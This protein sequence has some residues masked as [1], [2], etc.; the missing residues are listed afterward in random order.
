[1]CLRFELPLFISS[2]VAKCCKVLHTGSN[3]ILVLS[4]SVLCT[5]FHVLLQNMDQ[6]PRA[7]VI[8]SIL[9]STIQLIVN[10]FRYSLES[11]KVS[12]MASA[13]E[14]LDSR[15]VIQCG[16]CME[17][18][19]YLLN[20]V[21]LPCGHKFCEKCLRDHHPKMKIFTCFRCK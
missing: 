9:K 2:Q 3:F 16:N 5:I 8:L 17:V 15:H 13:K 14:D 19:G 21:V 18:D 10:F 6:Q 11:I 7:C 1:M 20:P 12:L 4:H